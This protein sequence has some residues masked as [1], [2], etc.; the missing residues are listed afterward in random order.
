MNINFQFY[1]KKINYNNNNIVKIKKQK[2][3]I[4]V[5]NIKNKSIIIQYAKITFEIIQEQ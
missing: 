2:K 3:I 5:K 4:N 1:L